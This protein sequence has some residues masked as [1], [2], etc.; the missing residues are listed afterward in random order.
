M[1]IDDEEEIKQELEVQKSKTKLNLSH[2]KHHSKNNLKPQSS[3]SNCLDIDNIQ[4]QINENREAPEAAEPVR[5]GSQH[6]GSKDSI[7]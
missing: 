4:V 7:N 2:L 1:K 5:V 3:D 6:Q